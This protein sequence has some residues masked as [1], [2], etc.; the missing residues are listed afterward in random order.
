VVGACRG[1]HSLCARRRR[2]ENSAHGPG[3]ITCAG[4]GGSHYV[5]CP[6]CTN[7]KQ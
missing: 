1:R 7:Q 2:C 5:A 6:S 3:D 4:L